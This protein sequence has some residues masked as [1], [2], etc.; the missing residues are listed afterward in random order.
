MKKVLFVCVHNSGRSQMAHAFLKRSG[1][2]IVEADSAGIMPGS[3]VDPVVVEAMKEVGIDIS[4]N[5]PRLITQDIVDDCDEVITMG[6]SI[7]EACPAKFIVS[8]DW[9]LADPKGQ[10]IGEVR[11]IRDEI[12][13]KVIDL[14]ER[15][16]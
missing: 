8:E 10:H 15:L 1:K 5:P 13:S 11:R 16:R 4:E 3:E 14:L 7:D 2:L 12:S 9:G 6:C